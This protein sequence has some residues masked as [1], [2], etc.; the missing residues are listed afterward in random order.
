MTSAR[1]E[2]ARLSAL[3][4]VAGAA[5]EGGGLDE[6]LQAITEGVQSAFGFDAAL[7]YFDP[8]AGG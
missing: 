1:Q 8:A 6:V 7:N 3:A 4:R 5:A 2:S